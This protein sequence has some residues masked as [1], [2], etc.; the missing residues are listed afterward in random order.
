MIKTLEFGLEEK[1]KESGVR[2]KRKEKI[3]LF[4]IWE[5]KMIKNSGGIDG[6]R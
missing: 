4:S 3:L 2:R 5:V 1:K 6:E